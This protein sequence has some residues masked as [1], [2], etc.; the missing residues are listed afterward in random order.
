MTAEP[1]HYTVT[2]PACG[3]RVETIAREVEVAV[4]RGVLTFR[5]EATSLK[6]PCGAVGGR[7]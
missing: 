6:H 2:C 3:A 5:L 4:D 7:A 1:L